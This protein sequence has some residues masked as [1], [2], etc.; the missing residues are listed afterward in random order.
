MGIERGEGNEEYQVSVGE[1]HL[2]CSF[3]TGVGLHYGKGPV[4]FIELARLN[5]REA[6]ISPPDRLVSS[7][8]LIVYCFHRM[9]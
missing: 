1:M 9:V 3:K 6:G 4:L 8:V 5:L 2:F 7:E